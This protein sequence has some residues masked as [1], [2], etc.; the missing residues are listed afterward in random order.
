VFSVP[1]RGDKANGVDRGMNFIR[2]VKDIEAMEIEMY[3]L[4]Y[5][6]AEAERGA[7]VDVRGL[8]GTGGKSV[9]CTQLT[10]KVLFAL[11]MLCR[12]CV[13]WYLQTVNGSL[14]NETEIDLL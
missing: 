10:E 1:L 11:N 2:P 12:V 13:L 5:I 9:A 14:I 8:T 3:I 4:I 7:L 6:S